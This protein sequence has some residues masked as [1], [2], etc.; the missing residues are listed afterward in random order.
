MMSGAHSTVGRRASLCCRSCPR[1]ASPR[2]LGQSGY[3]GNCLFGSFWFY[4]R[5]QFVHLCFRTPAGFGS[6]DLRLRE[7]D[8]RGVSRLDFL[9]GAVRMA[10]GYRNDARHYGSDR[11]EILR[12]HA[13]QS[14]G[15]LDIHLIEILDRSWRFL[16]TGHCFCHTARDRGARIVS[17]GTERAFPRRPGG[18]TAIGSA[19]K[20]DTDFNAVLFG[21]KRQIGEQAEEGDDRRVRSGQSSC[22]LGEE[23][24]HLS[25]LFVSL[26][27]KI[28]GRDF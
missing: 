9:S 8:R 13:T 10:G 25:E 14:S 11:G 16:A 21:S 26:I 3:M 6:L 27:D 17:R 24:A 22:A 23:A 28:F 1:A 5:L 18:D 7:P 4:C 20:L 15:R 12:S 19:L 2:E